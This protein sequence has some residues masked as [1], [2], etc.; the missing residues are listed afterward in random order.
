[1][2]VTPGG[3]RRASCFALR[4]MAVAFATGLLLALT[5]SGGIAGERLTRG[6]FDVALV[7]NA[8]ATVAA[9]LAM[10][11]TMRRIL[12]SFA[13]LD[14]DETRA[15]RVARRRAATVVVPQLVGAACG[16]T[17]VHLALR[18]EA[19]GAF[20]WL[21][22]KPA[23]WMNDLVAVSGALALVWAAAQGLEPK[24]LVAALVGV[25]LYRAT[26]PMWHLDHAPGGFSTSI[27]ELVVAQL[28]AVAF[29][30]GI[31]RS[32]MDARVR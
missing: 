12:V 27:Q 26:S 32:A 30:L 14:E 13:E 22:E 4:T 19:L 6:S 17:L 28:V 25:T 9:L 2:D 10:V 24:L 18:H 20:P 1:M 3:S 16:V 15:T 23:Q 21:S 31:F 11:P 8:M 5:T 29:A 7:A